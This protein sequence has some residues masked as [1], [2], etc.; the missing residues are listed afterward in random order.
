MVCVYVVCVYVVYVWCVYV[1]VYGVCY[2]VSVYVMVCVYLR[3]F[4]F[5]SQCV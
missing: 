2:G 1:H 4:V 5:L 3:V